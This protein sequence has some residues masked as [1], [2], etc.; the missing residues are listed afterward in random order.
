MAESK[1][2]RFSR[3]TKGSFRFWINQQYKWLKENYLYP[4][5]Y[6][7]DSRELDLWLSEFL[8]QEPLLNGVYSQ[9]VTLDK[10]RG[11]RMVGGRNTVLRY[12]NI[13]RGAE[14]GRGWRYFAS[15]QSGAFWRT[16]LGAVAEIGRNGAGG[17]LA[18][19]WHVDP[20]K[21]RLTGDPKA[22]LRYYPGGDT[23]LAQTWEPEDYFRT[24]SNPSDLEELNGLGKSAVF[25]SLSLALLM[26]AIYHHDKELLYGAMANGLLMLRCITEMQWVT[27][28]EA[29]AEELTAKEREFYS[30]MAIFFGDEEM[31]AKLTKLSEMPEGLVREKFVNQ[32]MYSY[33][34]VFGY[35]PREFWP[36]SGGTLGT[37]RET[38]EQAVKATTKGGLDW[39]LAWQDNFQRQ[40]P[41]NL[42][43]E[44][45]QRD[46]AGQILEA[47][48]VRTYA[49]AV[50]EMAQPAGSADVPT[51]T[52]EQ[53]RQLYAARGYIPEEWTFEEEDTVTTDTDP[54]G[55]ARLLEL[56]QVQR[57]CLD[58][59]REPIVEVVFSLFPKA[60]TRIRTLWRTGSE[61]LPR[62]L[63]VRS[64]NI[65]RQADGEILYDN[66]ELGFE[67]TEAD[68]DRA[69]GKY[70]ARQAEA[71]QGTMTA[72]P[73]DYLLEG[74]DA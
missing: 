64:A 54:T 51:L 70:E 46:D 49:Q 9:A 13:L 71:D 28:M 66:D 40:I 45:E 14:N 18:A 5:S 61:G 16:N 65:K 22:P 2:P 30:G 26:V 24:V 59:P 48:T 34:L 31:D 8:D 36:V 11:W 3:E 67:I 69:I 33:A 57:A 47:E 62:K 21:C 37:G 25:R 56:P 7:E 17:P 6:R 4:P 10:N 42:L 50:N 55:R 23:R 44:F 52:A 20:T 41:N 19:L 35:D 29:H 68:A 53:R 38:E 74:D 27:A 15:L 58:Y 12:T 1:Q 73:A 43:F 60:R 39:A 72:T 63:Y 32:L